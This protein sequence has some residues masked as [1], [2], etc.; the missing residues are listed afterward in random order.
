MKK[1]LFAGVPILLSLLA[2]GCRTDNP[3]PEIIGPEPEPTIR[4]LGRDS[5]S[6]G[7]Y[8]GI[9]ID[10][11]ADD[12]FTVLEDYRENKVIAYLGAVNNYFSDVTDLENRLHLFEWVVLDEKFD[13]DSG[14]QIQLESGKVKSITLNNRRE[15]RQWPETAGSKEAIQ[16][17]DQSQE[18]YSKLVTLS[19]QTEFAHKFER[20]VLSTRHTYAL[21]DADKAKLPWTFIYFPEPQGIIEQARVYFKD[22]K[23]DYIIVDRFE[24]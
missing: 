10:S 18:L 14:V 24:R 7:D 19:K 20:I 22:K 4:F 13:T 9:F 16:I 8:R 1:H 15:L 3:W 17:G 11:P 23:V 6:E 2:A 5:I 21:H 12:V